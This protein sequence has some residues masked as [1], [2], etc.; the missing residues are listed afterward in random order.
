SAFSSTPQAT[1]PHL[2][3]LLLGTYDA[4]NLQNLSRLS[5]HHSKSGPRTINSPPSYPPFAEV[6]KAKSPKLV[7]FPYLIWWTFWDFS[8]FRISACT[9]I[10]QLS[11]PSTYDYKTYLIGCALTSSIALFRPISSLAI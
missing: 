10:V 7:R 1:A 5:I 6:L 4:A 11:T 8:T 3:P 2:V 9:A